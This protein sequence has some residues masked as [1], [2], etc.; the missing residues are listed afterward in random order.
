[1]GKIYSVLSHRLAQLLHE[2]VAGIAEVS[3]WLVSRIGT[4]IDEPRLTSVSVRLEPG[5]AL[6]DVVRPCQ[7]IIGEELARMP[8]LVVELA[9]GEHP[10]Y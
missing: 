7:D 9:R 3:T 1:V 8:Q 4:P 5:A 2:R 10:T 6:A